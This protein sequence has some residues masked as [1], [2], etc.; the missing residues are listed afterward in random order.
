MK[1]KFKCDICIFTSK[2]YLTANVNKNFEAA[3]EG[4]KNSVTYAVPGSINLG[5]FRICSFR[6]GC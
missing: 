2:Q 6:I 3:Y 4:K 5:K 1:K